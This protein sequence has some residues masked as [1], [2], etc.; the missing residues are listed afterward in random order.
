MTVGCVLVLLLLC[1]CSTK[2][3][4][5]TNRMFHNLT[6][7]FN[8]YWN[9][10]KILKEGDKQLR[11][12]VKDDYSKVLRV[13]NYGTQQ[14]GMTMNSVMDRSIE[15]TAIC[16]QKQSMKFGGRERVKWIDDA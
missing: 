13:Y 9:G 4:T 2:K 8:I 6:S 1:G 12:K 5:L 15:K 7:H 14:D 3:N 11:D 10:E 16:V